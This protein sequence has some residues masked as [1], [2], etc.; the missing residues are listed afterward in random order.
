[1]RQEELKMLSEPYASQDKGD[2]HRRFDSVIGAALPSAEKLAGEILRDLD[3]TDYGVKWWRALPTQER[4][5]IGDYLYQCV[6]GIQLNLTEAK[7]HYFEWL[8][9]QRR[10]NER[11]AN[12]VSL[13]PRRGATFK[14]PASH[15]AIDDLPSRLERLHLG[16]FFRAVGSSLDCLGGA[17]IG[18][19]GLRT[20]LRYGDL[21]NAEKALQNIEVSDGAGTQLQLGFLRFFEDA[22]Q[23][24]GPENWIEWTNQ[25]R[26]MFV[27]RGRAASSHEIIPREHLFYDSQ[28]QVI[29]RATSKLH[30]ARFPDRSDIEALIIG[31]D[32]WLNEDANDTLTGIF[33]SCLKLEKETCERLCSIWAERRND[34][35]LI[36]QPVEQWN[37]KIRSCKFS[38][39]QPS[40]EPFGAGSL[41]LNASLAHRMRVAAV[42][43][44]HRSLWDESKWAD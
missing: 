16:G 3:P 38:G 40:N 37:A 13:D 31:K 2:L 21:K 15:S 39:Y 28:G 20:S 8:D 5:L 29:P 33:S 25:Y 6:N 22:K 34:P 30:L 9:A 19:L 44:A 24:A 41:N 35:L 18:V 23:T 11:I 7:L 27:H 10:G 36:E 4:I 17:I 26:N 1:M 42:D 43:D 32:T 14:H 12:G